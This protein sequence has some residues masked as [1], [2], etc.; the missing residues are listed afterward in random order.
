[1][2]TFPNEGTVWVVVV[3][4]VTMIGDSIGEVLIASGIRANYSWV[5]CV[6]DKANA[7]EA[8]DMGSPSS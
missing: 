1:M 4:V 3:V 7:V 2:G 5:A 8:K 6:M